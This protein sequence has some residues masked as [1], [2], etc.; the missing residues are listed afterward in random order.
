MKLKVLKDNFKKGLITTEK[1]IGKN[2]NLP[3]L[4]NI[5]I[6]AKK[7]FL[8]LIA[9]DLEI[10]IKYWMLAKIEKEGNITIP[11]KLLTNF[12]SSI[13]ETEISLEVKK[14]KLLINY[15][16]NFSEIQGQPSDDFPIIPEIKERNFIEVNIIPFCSGIAQTASF[17]AI[18]QA[19]PEISG[20]YFSF[21]KDRLIIAATDSFRLAEKTI[22]F[23][24]PL[25][26]LKEYSFIL[27]QRAAK[28]IVNIFQEEK[29]ELSGKNGENK[30]RVY[31]A[32]NQVMFEK[33]I[34]EFNQAQIQFV[35]R[36]ID[37]EYPNYQDIIPKSYK[38]KV[39]IDRDK[40]L[41]QIKIASLFSSRA[42]EVKIKSNKKD[43]IL[44][45]LSSN[46]DLGE[47]KSVV[48]A[49]ID[50]AENEASFNHRFLIEGLL[51]IKS[52][53]VSLELNSDEGPAVLRPIGDPSYL[54]V[55]MPIKS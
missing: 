4:N 36:L 28:E 20:I 38:T 2:L 47:N 43:G 8:N 14:N 26:I 13:P 54:Y 16:K 34:K 53:E 45:I 39:T 22:F 48:A 18:T 7:N 32:E 30:L 37:G 55:V 50:G 31:F 33:F 29:E 25:P 27:P 24:N 10:A 41:D 3:I 5:L 44:E 52:K 1:A 51:N 9:T 11:A 6:S 40:F 23:E 42:N 15:G 21:Q 12:V 35:S 49:V 17:C 46:P 19:R